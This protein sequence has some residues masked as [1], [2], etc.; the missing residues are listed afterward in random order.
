MGVWLVL[1]LFTTFASSRY[2][3]WILCDHSMRNK[4]LAIKASFF[5]S[6]RYMVIAHPLIPIISP[7][8]WFS[9]STGKVLEG[10]SP[11][12]CIEST[13]LVV[14]Y[15]VIKIVSRHW[16][17]VF[18][19]HIYN[20]WS[21]CLKFL[22]LVVF[23]KRKF[24]LDQV[25]IGQQLKKKSSARSSWHFAMVPGKI[26]SCSHHDCTQISNFSHGTK[27]LGNRIWL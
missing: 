3:L 17:G 15:K 20:Y 10:T 16:M 18:L 11:Y 7:W 9:N 25:E 13:K 4:K 27:I 1:F 21:F 5:F 2:T 26:T 8:Q 23:S 14:Q 6:K 24:Q 22:P 12:L 19:V